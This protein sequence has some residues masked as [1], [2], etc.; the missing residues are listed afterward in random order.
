MQCPYCGKTMEEGLI[1]SPQELAWLP[2]RKRPLLGR[3][4][5]HDGAVVLSELS[6]MRGSA[7]LAFLCRD[8][9]KI[10][11]DYAEGRSDLNQE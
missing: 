8:C 6:M 11:I 9:G 4:Q 7:V 5:F 1:Q 10:M 3:A 2:G